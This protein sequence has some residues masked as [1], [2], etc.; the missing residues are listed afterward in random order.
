MEMIFKS[1]KALNIIE[2]IRSFLFSDW[3]FCCLFLMGG[4]ITT[5]DAFLPDKN[6]VFMGTLF[7]ILV[8]AI[9][10][11]MSD[12]IMATIAP[13]MITTLVSLRCYDSY[14][15]FMRHKWIAI[16]IIL[17]VGFHFFTSR[18]RAK[19]DGYLM[20]PMIFV[21]I[22]IL[23]GGVGFITAKEY[24]SLTSIYHMVCLGFGMVY[25][26]CMFGSRVGINKSYEPTD[27]ICRIMVLTGAFASFLVF[28]YY[29]V[30]VK[31]FIA[32]KA[33]LFIQWRNNCSTLLMMSIPFAFLKAHKN[34]WFAPFG[35]IFYFAILLTDSRGG[36][37]FG[38]VTLL[39]SLILF[40]AMDKKRRKIYLIICGVGVVLIGVL[41]KM[42]TPVFEHTLE[43]L[44]SGLTGFI[45]GDANE[46]RTVHYARGINDFLNNPI[47]GTG[48]GYMGN[49]DVFES[50][51]FALCWYH[52]E[53]IQIAASLGVVGIIA[54]LYQFVKR[55]LLI[56]KKTNLFNITVFLSYI[57]LE[58]MSLVNP[59][60]F[61][62]LPYVLIITLF[63]VIVEKNNKAE[64][65][66][67]Q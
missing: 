35:F 14:D 65:E 44:I 60:V 48:L 26:Y 16:P 10:F 22:A 33:P 25:F 12:D 7:F 39:M 55:N 9:T 41:W 50:K 34:P 8:T 45:L 57:S 31:E 36:M 56:F 42:F 66:K 11:I 43:R 32:T 21:S 15:A 19:K 29:A 38:F 1:S 6:I 40:V 28:S 62:P 18:H 51:D 23:L 2:K 67:I 49:R 52:C 61:C 58:L 64:N 27:L 5:V 20:K 17:S 37:L 47:F 3:W 30:N 46:I 4:I 54:Y 63:F 59:G 53:P 13:L 24:F